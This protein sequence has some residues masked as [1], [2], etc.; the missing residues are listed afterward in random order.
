M[1]FRC[2]LTSLRGRAVCSGTLSKWEGLSRSRMGTL[3]PLAQ[4]PEGWPCGWGPGGLVWAAAVGSTG[5]PL[6]HCRSG[7]DPGWR[8]HQTFSPPLVR[9]WIR[10][11]RVGGL[12]AQRPGRVLNR[13]LRGRADWPRPIST[14][15]LVPRP[16]SRALLA[17]NHQ[18]S[19]CSEVGSLQTGSQPLSVVRSASSGPG[20][21]QGR[22][23]LKGGR[24]QMTGSLR[25]RPDQL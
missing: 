10:A 3:R 7:Q 22:L 17:Q 25:D 21:P 9:G 13:I 11:N 8:R 23:D 1:C 18:T 12:W 19:R 14:Q 24:R 15:V 6:G 2:A 4:V 16:S 5:Q 20:D